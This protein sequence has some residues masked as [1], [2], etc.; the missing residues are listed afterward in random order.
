MAAG[1]DVLDGSGIEPRATRV[2]EDPRQRIQQCGS[3]PCGRAHRQHIR[4][5]RGLDD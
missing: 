4:G 3:N 5:R 1:A 2:A